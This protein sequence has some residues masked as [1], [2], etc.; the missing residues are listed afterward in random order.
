MAK[1]IE[2]E[3][4]LK[5]NDFYNFILNSEPFVEIKTVKV[6]KNVV[7]NKSEKFTCLNFYETIEKIL[8]NITI[9]KKM[10]PKLKEEKRTITESDNNMI[11]YNSFYDWIV[12]EINRK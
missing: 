2:K 3:F 8:E 9:E 10:T 5:K 4:S 11:G 7:I 6:S 1:K 12:Q